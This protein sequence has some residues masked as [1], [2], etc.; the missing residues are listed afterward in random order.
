[1]TRK[2][3][4][5]LILDASI[6][7]EEKEKIAKE[8]SEAITKAS[9]KVINSKVWLEKQKFTFRIKRVMEG[10]YYLI[11]FECGP[12]LIAEINQKLRLNEKI[13]RFS[14]MSGE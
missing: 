4:L 1:M 8:S 12:S 11:N 5:V 14:I 7:V 10:T 2:Y 9:G 6:P 13:L 3:E